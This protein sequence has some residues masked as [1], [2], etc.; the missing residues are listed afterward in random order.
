MGFEGGKGGGEGV[1]LHNCS[2]FLFFFILCFFFAKK[3]GSKLYRQ[4]LLV[5]ANITF[6]LFLPRCEYAVSLRI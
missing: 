2:M 1:L 4:L 6:F 5:S 3:L